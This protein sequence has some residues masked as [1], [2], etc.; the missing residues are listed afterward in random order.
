MS[1]KLSSW[2]I[3]TSLLSIPVAIGIKKLIRRRRKHSVD[4]SRSIAIIGDIYI[5]LMVGPLEELPDWGQDRTAHRPIQVLPGGSALNTSI[6]IRNFSSLQETR[7][8]GNSSPSRIYPLLFSFVGSDLF[9]NFILDKMREFG[10]SSEGVEISKDEATGTCIVLSG[11]RDRSFISHSGIISKMR[12]N[13]L[14]FRKIFEPKRGVRHLHISGFYNC[15]DLAQDLPVVLERARLNNISTSLTPQYDASENWSGLENILP[16]LTIILLNEIE[17]V[18][19]SRLTD[20]HDLGA[21]GKW[22]LD[23]GVEVVVITLG[24]N[25]AIAFRNSTD[26][27]S[28]EVKMEVFEQKCKTLSLEEIVDPTGAGD[29][30]N[31]GF[32]CSWVKDSE[33]IQDSLR[34]GCAMGTSVVQVLG[35]STCP[36]RANFERQIL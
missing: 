19:I 22:F 26:P 5:D 30:F 18:K 23:Q 31:A 4:A 3:L 32:L 13:D 34:Q 1:K 12:L 21:I 16:L 35:A 24:K 2:V 20:A 9:G 36:S 7:P 25:G 10:I 28:S 11:S 17:A 6:Q 14:K 15:V 27:I 33:N 29:A 8:I